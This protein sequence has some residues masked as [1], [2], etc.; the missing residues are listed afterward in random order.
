MQETDLSS[1]RLNILKVVKEYQ[2]EWKKPPT[3]REMG[4]AA[5]IT[6]TS[7]VT[8]NLRRLRDKGYVTLGQNGESRGTLL[9][10]KGIGEISESISLLTSKESLP[11]SE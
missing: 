6:S 5:D 8:N 1:R 2:E 10:P 3:V 4:E 9:T 11:N 7:V